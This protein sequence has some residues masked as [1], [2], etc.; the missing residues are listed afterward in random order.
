MELLLNKC[1]N[2]VDCDLKIILYFKE[3]ELHSL[4]EKTK[5]L[6]F[7]QEKLDAKFGSM[8]YLPY[9]PDEKKYLFVG[10]GKKED[11][12]YAQLREIGSK[13][14][15]KLK[16]FKN[17]QNA[18]VCFCSFD[19][20]PSALKIF[21]QGFYIGDYSFD[22][23]KSEK[24]EENSNPNLYV[25]LKEPETCEKVFN[26]AKI[27]IEAMN[28]ARDLINEPA[29][30]VYPEII[31][32]TAQNIQGLETKI[33]N[34]QEIE[35]MKMGA[36]LGV[37]QGSIHEPKFIHMKYTPSG[38]IKKK[39]AIIGKS[40]TF[41]SGG[42][43]IKPATSMRNMKEDMSGSACVLGIMNV[44][45]KLCPN[46]EVHGIIATCENMPSGKAYKPGDV[47]IAKNGKTIEVDNTD[48]EGRLTLAD[49][50]CYADELGVDEIV[51]I[52]TL[53][54]ACMVAL[55]SS[56]AGIMGTNQELVNT[57]IECGKQGGEKLW[58]LPMFDE[59]FEPLQSDI[60]DMKNS[61]S[62]YGGASSAACFL[63]KFVENKNWAHI[64]IA[65]TAFVSKSAKEMLKGAAGAGVRT[66]I[67]YILK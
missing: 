56:C 7:E 15:Q 65:G 63:S 31:A 26:D 21:T 1:G 20:Q 64:D 33:Y 9:A 32:Q 51:D 37:A 34:K 42:L 4:D 57:L 19:D 38:E 8:F 47:L 2:H 6:V 54:G 44:L 23:Y 18:K 66:L 59:Y 40:I 55:G 12:D 60:A 53:T 30:A 5:Q 35:E 46:V 22:K 29:C 61:G 25:C 24:K 17:V 58:Q 62:R 27:T 50:L 36:F 11:F 67:E 49:A 13:V 48:A 16:T 10:L 43:D 14:A 28:F 3:S 41:D 45:P 39:I 52:A